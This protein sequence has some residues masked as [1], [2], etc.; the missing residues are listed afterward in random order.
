MIDWVIDW[1][2]QFRAGGHAYVFLCYG[3]NT[4]LNVVADKVGVGAAVLI[5]ACSPVAGPAST[6]LISQN[7]VRLELQRVH[8]SYCLL[9]IDMAIFL[10]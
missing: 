10:V 8:L 4:M 1:V 3:I 7:S 5:R 9:T 2:M 6:L